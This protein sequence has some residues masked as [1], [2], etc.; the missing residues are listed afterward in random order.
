MMFMNPKL[1]PRKAKS[2]TDLFG[3]RSSVANTDWQV[4]IVF[5]QNI[6]HICGSKTLYFYIANTAQDEIVVIGVV[7]I[8]FSW[9]RS[10]LKLSAENRFAR[11]AGFCVH[12]QRFFKT[13][14]CVSKTNTNSNTNTNTDTN[15]NTQLQ[16]HIQLCK[17]SGFSEE[18]RMKIFI[19][20]QLVFRSIF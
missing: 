19:F 16:I 7:T 20:L 2:R 13:W 1:Y 12:T 17:P 10:Q 11:V 18:V 15:S 4:A 6:L 9:D 14:A 5:S 3:W 8:V